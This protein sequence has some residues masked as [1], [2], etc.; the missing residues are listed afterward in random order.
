MREKAYLATLKS[1]LKNIAFAQELYFTNNNKYAQNTNKLDEY[2]ASP[3]VKVV[4]VASN[5]GWR[6]KATLTTNDKYQCAIFSGTGGK[7]FAPATDDGAIACMSKGGG[8]L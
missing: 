1:D 8:P 7:S 2:S 6:A 3:D 4:M 5:G